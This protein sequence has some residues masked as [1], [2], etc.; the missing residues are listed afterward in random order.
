MIRARRWIP[1]WTAL[2]LFALGVAAQCL[3]WFGGPTLRPA[4]GPFTLLTYLGL[5]ALCNR[6]RM[7]VRF[8]GVEL[9]RGPLP[10][11][12]GSEWI[13]REQIAGGYWR[14]NYQG[15]KSGDVS[16]WETGIVH[17]DGRWLRNPAQFE[18]EMQAAEETASMMGILGVREIGRVEGLPP[19]QDRRVGIA[20]VVWMLLSLATLG[21]AVVL[22]YRR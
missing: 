7:T 6:T 13:P 2:V 19:K 17:R 11:G 22:E 21:S 16:H 5:V 20:T 8:A 9:R 4:V 15:P 18:S 3:L 10:T 14:W 12:A 1:L